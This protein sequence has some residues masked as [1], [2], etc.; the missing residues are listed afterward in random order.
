MKKIY[1]GGNLFSNGEKNQRILEA[2]LLREKYGNSIEVYNPIE[3]PMNENKSSLPTPNTIFIND[4]NK[5]KES[6]IIFCDVS[7]EDP[8]LMAELG[9]ACEM[10]KI[11]I[12]F[13]SDIRLSTANK[14]EIPTMGM[15]HFI[16]GLILEKGNMYKN[17]EEAI[18]AV[19]NF[20]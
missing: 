20:L 1:L 16:L 15:N 7:F 13:N 9:L 17:L 5:L 14:Y 6:D 19:S 3:A 4:Y 2:K 8:G 18:D 11:I 10:N 12:A